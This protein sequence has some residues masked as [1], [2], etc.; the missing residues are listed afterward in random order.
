MRQSVL[1]SVLRNHITS[2]RHRKNYKPTSILLLLLLLL[3][4]LLIQLLVCVDRI[5]RIGETGSS[6]KILVEKPMSNISLRGLGIDRIILKIKLTKISRV[7]VDWVNY[8][9]QMKTTTALCRK[10]A[11]YFKFQ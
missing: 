2:L 11:E 5:T 9:N 4:T 7:G 1:Q 3:L 10:N 8:P 6:Y